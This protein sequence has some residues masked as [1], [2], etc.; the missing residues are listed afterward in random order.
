MDGSVVFTERGDVYRSL[1]LACG[2]CVGCRLE[3]SRQWAVRCLHEAQCHEHNMFI[4]LTYSD[5]CLPSDN[6]LHYRD[7]QL[8][9]KRLRRKYG[10]VRFF[11]CGEYGEQFSRPHY[12][13]CIFGL[14]FTD[15]VL[16]GRTDSGSPLFK[17]KS[18][19]TLWPYGFCSVG[20]VTFESAAY[21][22]RY[23]M[24]KVTGYGADLHYQD[25]DISSGE[26]T[27]RTPEFCRMSLK[28]GIGGNWF[29][30]FRTDVF[31]HDRVVINGKATKPP[32][33]YDKLYARDFPDEFEVTQFD[34]EVKA[35]LLSADNTDSR[36]AAKRICTEARIERLARKI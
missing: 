5:E 18:L 4:T 2:Q 23:I 10:Q 20:A 29:S 13:A 1:Q 35:R 6:S 7:F 11:M 36:L 32:R 24:K 25:I 22:A 14:T 28:P 19:E 15:L 30:K 8:F 3:R 9:L 26:V 16:L 12:H 33:Y 31:P 34:R 17:S 27:I 21:V